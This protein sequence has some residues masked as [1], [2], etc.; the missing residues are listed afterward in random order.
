MAQN[1]F[2]QKQNNIYRNILCLVLHYLQYGVHFI[3]CINNRAR[4]TAEKLYLNYITNY[5]TSLI[6]LTT[7]VEI[8]MRNYICATFFLVKCGSVQPR[9]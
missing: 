5:Y 2:A 3:S 9:N 4:K 8:E 6:A 1:T 7:G